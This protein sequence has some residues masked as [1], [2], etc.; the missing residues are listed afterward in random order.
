MIISISRGD[1]PAGLIAYLLGT[2][3]ALREDAS[4]IGIENL[5]SFETAPKEMAYTASL[6]DRVRNYILHI[7]VSPAPGERLSEA[8][9]DIV[10]QSIDAELGLRGH[11]S[12]TVA[13][14]EGRPHR[15]RG[16][17]IIHPD[18]HRTPT[19]SHTDTREIEAS[20]HR[21]SRSERSGKDRRAWD[22]NIKFRLQRLAREL[23]TSLGLACANAPERWRSGKASG[24][25]ST[26]PS[27]H[28]QRTGIVPI[29]VEFG[30]AIRRALRKPSWAERIADLSML[31]I[32]AQLYVGP[33]KRRTGISFFVLDDPQRRC[34]GST[35]GNDYGL[36]A[37]ERRAGETFAAFLAG[38]PNVATAPAPLGTRKPDPLYERYVAYKAEQRTASEAYRLRL[39]IARAEHKLAIDEEK[40]RQI[41]MRSAMRAGAD[42]R[43][44]RGITQNTL[45]VER[46]AIAQLREAQRRELRERFPR[47]LPALGW[48]DWLVQE[49]EAGDGLAQ[50]RLERNGAMNRAR[51]YPRQPTA[52]ERSS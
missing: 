19:G 31:G 44:R 33:N 1:D 3:T 23:E 17:N 26:S 48:T 12:M 34:T 46:L 43:H 41:A 49:A 35:L 38:E 7:S 32:G 22:S 11:Q 45:A 37:L 21:K 6:S 28:E 47:P 16:I 2:A 20:V 27:K 36:G 29:E 9:W 15:H 39:Q 18:T 10:W 14:N 5:A 30:D 4:L 52:V 42:R 13:H 8:Q 25:A 50:Q 24:H 51:A 40:R